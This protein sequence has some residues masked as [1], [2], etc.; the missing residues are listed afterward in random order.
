MFINPG[1]VVDNLESP[2][3]VIFPDFFA[4]TDET[5]ELRTS[6]QDE[7]EGIGEFLYDG[8]TFLGRDRHMYI[9]GIGESTESHSGGVVIEI[10]FEETDL[11]DFGAFFFFVGKSP[12]FIRAHQ[13]GIHNQATNSSSWASIPTCRRASFISDN[14]LG[15]KFL[16]SLSFDLD[17]LR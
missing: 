14:A 4:I 1:L 9:M 17:F 10:V 15:P 16:I 12:E 11:F 3:D 13:I 5:T 2:V 8:C 7:I 6:W